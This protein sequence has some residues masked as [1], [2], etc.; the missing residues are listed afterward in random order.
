MPT[1]T[2]LRI[3]YFSIS[4]AQDFLTDIPHSLGTIYD[5]SSGSLVGAPSDIDHLE[6]HLTL[7]RALGF[8][9]DDI[10]QPAL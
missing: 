7:A 4:D 6:G 1:K 10:P 9:A 5:I 8:E 3:L 2:K